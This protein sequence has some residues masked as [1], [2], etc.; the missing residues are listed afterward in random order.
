M[1]FLVQCGKQQNKKQEPKFS[2]LY[3]AV[4][5]MQMLH[6]LW[7]EKFVFYPA[8]LNWLLKL[9]NFFEKNNMTETI[10]L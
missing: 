3:P 7:N 6:D 8:N 10:R 4:Q 5:Q 9:K 2:P 1:S